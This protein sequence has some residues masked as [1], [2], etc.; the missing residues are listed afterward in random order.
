MRVSLLALLRTPVIPN[1]GSGNAALSW[2]TMASREATKGLVDFSL[3]NKT[4]ENEHGFDS[5]GGVMTISTTG[6]SSRF[7]VR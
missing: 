6:D 1:S 7:I 3:L 2:A 4:V 5:N